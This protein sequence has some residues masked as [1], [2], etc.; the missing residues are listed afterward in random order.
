MKSELFAVGKIDQVLGDGF[1]RVTLDANGHQMLC[2]PSGRMLK[3]NRIRLTQGDKV[4][5]FMSEYDLAR[6]IIT[7]RL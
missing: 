1:F 7:Y 4:R 6:G 5:V 3:V 2:K